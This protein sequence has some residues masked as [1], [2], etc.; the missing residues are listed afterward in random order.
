LGHI[1]LTRKIVSEMTYIVSS[2]TLNPTIPYHATPRQIFTYRRSSQLFRRQTWQICNKVIIKDP[3]TALRNV[4]YVCVL[5]NDAVCSAY[6]WYSSMRGEACWSV[7][8]AISISMA[9]AA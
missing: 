7:A 2:G 6:N 5:C 1:S 9:A 4:V 3:T 8:A